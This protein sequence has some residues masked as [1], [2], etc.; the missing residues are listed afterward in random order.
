MILA[1]G[2]AA[3]G[4]LPWGWL[5]VALGATGWFSLARLVR[6]QALTLASSD[7]TAAA[8]AL[9]A[10]TA[11]IAARHI[12][13]NV[14]GTIAAATVLAFAHSITLETALS[15][16]GQGVAI[17]TASWGAL[18]NEG[19][20]QASVAPWLMVAP[21]LAIVVTVLAAGALAEGVERGTRWH[22]ADPHA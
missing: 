4:R 17:P 21:A 15:F 8:R 19:R 14:T 3:L 13:P 16:I 9:G 1:H 2:E 12:L 20:A 11:R 7:F 5:A 22:G 10:G 6:G 18:I